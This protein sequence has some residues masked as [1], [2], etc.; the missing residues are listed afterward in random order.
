[1]ARKVIS[2]EIGVKTIKVCEISYRKQRPFV[3]RCIILET[4]ED[5]FED[6][7]IRDKDKL[8]SFLKE[9]LIQEKIKG[10]KVIF[11][12]TSSKIANREITIPMV[13]DN[14][15]QTI[16]E[17]NAAEYF[18]VEIS[19]YVFAYCILERIITKDEK[20]LRLSVLAAP[21][22]LINNYYSV[23]RL[24]GYEVEA[25]DYSGNS[26]VQLLKR[27][28]KTEANLLIQ[29]NE[30]TTLVSILEKNILKLQRTIPYGTS[31]IVEAVLNNELYQT[32][33]E[34]EAW[35]LL[36]STDIIAANADSSCENAA[37]TITDV[38]EDFAD[39]ERVNRENITG[40]FGYLI[41]NILRVLDY[42]FSKNKDKSIQTAYVFGQG[43]HII[44]IEDLLSRETGIVTKKLEAL[45]WISFHKNI[46]VSPSEKSEYIACIGAGIN[47]LKLVPKD[48][49]ILE[50]RKQFLHYG[51]ILTGI[52]IFSV[53]LVFTSY[54]QYR[55]AFN[56]NKDLI[57]KV[58]DLSELNTIEDGYKTAERN[59][60]R[61]KDIYNLT[62][63]SNEKLDYI[64]LVLEEI[65]PAKAKVQ[66]MDFSETD[67]TFGFLADSKET[68]A[69]VLQ[70]LKSIP[71]FT[72]IS[73][74]GISEFKESNGIISVRFQVSGKFAI[75]KGEGDAGEN[76]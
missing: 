22:N 30:N 39:S 55:L 71:E 13:K 5:T 17:T 29:I 12:I 15:I 51:K 9:K 73:T 49:F 16:I 58:N 61:I 38:D 37:I 25:I 70:Q 31:S 67:F 42:Y 19:E 63:N 10:E 6:G 41:S 50:K 18:P 28:V 56:E 53:L 54:I 57:K 1:M 52:T 23:A 20:K 27:E 60:S 3:H 76:E 11:T 36:C 21:D 48:Y 44:G 68:A 2:I 74:G 64:L 26:I 69:K 4:P 33:N 45:T 62:V 65:L 14:L 35:Q 7:Y 32:I 72:D 34:T 8:T 46:Q 59:Y 24:L 47:P 40:S 75:R 43:A 66:T